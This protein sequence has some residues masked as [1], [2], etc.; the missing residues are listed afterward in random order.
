MCFYIYMRWCN[1]SSYCTFLLL[2]AY[3]CVH[4]PLNPSCSHVG[5][6]F[7]PQCAV[8]Q[9]VLDVLLCLWTDILTQFVAL[10]L[11]LFHS[12]SLSLSVHLLGH[13]VPAWLEKQ[14]HSDWTKCPVHQWEALPSSLC[15]SLSLDFAVRV[16]VC[17]CV[18]AY[19]QLTRGSNKSTCLSTASFLPLP[20]YSSS[21]FQPHS[22]FFLPL[23][24]LQ[25]FV[26][27]SHLCS[28]ILFWKLRGGVIG[29]ACLL[30]NH[31]L[32]AR[33]SNTAISRSSYR[34]L[35][36]C[37]FSDQVTIH[38]HNSV[39]LCACMHTGMYIMCVDV[40]MC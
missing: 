30:I 24:P 20:H 7:A 36:P 22:S 9:G 32:G 1:K 23:S 40:R 21:S 19:S 17:S 38:F 10:A 18:C 16:C 14:A 15:S 35:C 33:Q 11:S 28:V 31:C 6:N 37:G 27:L 39:F 12:L 13:C 29:I 26:H 25:H 3:A 5:A 34:H 8:C 2:F 4:A